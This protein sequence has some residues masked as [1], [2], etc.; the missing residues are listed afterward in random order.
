[1]KKKQ[2][3][4]VPQAIRVFFRY[5]NAGVVLCCFAGAGFVLGAGQ[6]LNDLVPRSAD[7]WDYRPR[8]ATEIYST[9]VHKDGTETHTRLARLFTED[10]EPVALRDISD[11]LKHATVAIEDRRFWEHNGVSPRDIMRAV[12]VDLRHQ[13]TK[14]GASTITQ[15]VVRSI[16][17][18]RERTIDRK[19]KE[20]FMAM[21][22][23]RLYSKE[24]ILEMY[25]NQTCYGHGA[26]GVKTAAKLYY[27]KAPGDLQVHEAAM[28]AGLPQWPVGYSP[29]RH[30]ERCRKR[31]NGVLIWMEREGRISPKKCEQAMATPI[32]KGLEPLKERG[33]VAEHAPHFTHWVIRQ[34][35]SEYGSEAVYQGGLKV[36]T[37]L[38]L[39]LQK[40]AEEELAKQVKRLRD[41]GSI[42][43]GVKG[44]QGALAC[45]EV[46]TGRVLAMAGGVGP[47]QE[48]QMNLAHPD[49][50]PYG[51][52]PGSSFKPYVWA[53]ALENGYGPNSV[54]S[55][56]PISIGRWSPANYSASQAG[57]FTLRRALAQSVNLVS[58]RLVRKMGVAKVQKLACQ[59]LNVPKSRI[60]AVPAMAL[61]VS[62][63]SPLEQALGYCAF[64]NAGLRPTQR[65]IR[66]IEDHRGQVLVRYAPE[67]VRV[68]RSTTAQ[69]MLSM[70]RTVVQSGTGKRARSCGRPCG[71]KTGTTNSAK[72]VWWV[73]VTPEL[74]AAV[75]IGNDRPSRM[76]GATGG[77]W[78]GP[79]WARFI[80]Q[81]SDILGCDGHFPE[82]P[83]VTATRKSEP[84]EQKGTKIEVCIETGLRAGPN[85]PAR[86]TVWIKPGE[87]MPGICDLHSGTRP[88]ATHLAPTPDQGPRPTGAQTVRVCPTSGLRAGPWCPSSVVRSYADGGPSGYC[89]VHGPPAGS[90]T[91]PPATSRPTPS[92]PG[93]ML[94]EPGDAVPPEPGGT[95]P[96]SPAAPEP[97]AGD[98]GAPPEPDTPPAAGGGDGAPAEHTAPGDNGD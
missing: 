35:K 46:R 27:G 73:G 47:Y 10:R 32:D 19:V 6:Q 34:L 76:Y 60:E 22:M 98:G 70:L 7:L 1:M 25:L 50:P 53:C 68:I 33:V 91:G 16:W 18:N 56:D 29:Y 23:E 12:W 15:Q 78:C 42:K 2:K 20:A 38:D 57:P 69:S 75:W 97:A 77:G 96:P 26:F 49:G 13:K 41:R 67:R 11:N 64:A 87:E 4:R 82:G 24:E 61:G 9:E 66:R 72:N 86:K 40:V 89:T 59:M 71:G 43:R 45:V 58:V 55:A 21:E 93:S 48:I 30:P 65:C 90:S 28:I 8:L 63:V 85:C 74:S 92:E 17:L 3:N 83:G 52:Q 5:L 44:G 88:L 31:R 95:L 94:S 54:F 36:Y 79:V 37:S 14:Q 51:R 84:G 81:A 39:R 62:N 80:K